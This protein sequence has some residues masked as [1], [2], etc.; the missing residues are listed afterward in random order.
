M[1]SEPP[2]PFAPP[3]VDNDL[4]GTNVG[5]VASHYILAT[6]GERL[7]AALIDGAIMLIPFMLMVFGLGVTSGSTDFENSTSEA[8]AILLLLVCA[9][10]FPLQWYLIAT[11]G[12]TLGK[13]ALKI[14][15]ELLDG[16]PV[17]FFTGV[18]LRNWIL[19]LANMVIGVIG[20]IDV[21]FIFGH[22]QRCLHDLIA[23]T[24]VVAVGPEDSDVD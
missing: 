2:N 4:G 13:M 22:E 12:Q 18:F 5:Q 21:L 23:N 17:N 16:R 9:A 6:R 15:I 1:N 11:R 3:K 24:R 8:L 10:Q 19:G 20:L 14:R 7:L